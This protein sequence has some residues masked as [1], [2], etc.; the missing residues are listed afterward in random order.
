MPAVGEQS[1]QSS[2]RAMS[3]PMRQS[4]TSSTKIETNSSKYA[5]HE[6]ELGL[7]ALARASG[8]SRRAAQALSE[9]GSLNVAH[10]LLWDWSK[11]FSDLYER[12]CRETQPV[13]DRE[14]AQR[15][16]ATAR[17]LQEIGEQ[18]V[19]RIADDAEN[20]NAGQAANA[21]QKVSV[22]RGIAIDKL[23]L[24]RN[25]PTEIKSYSTKDT[26]NALGMLATK[27]G[28]LFP[29]QTREKFRMLAGP[30]FDAEAVEIPPEE[31]D[32]LAAS[33]DEDAER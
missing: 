3:K 31:S 4:A 16:E 22:S 24:Y 29:E 15:E 7:R 1:G 9:S 2:E 27:Y 32:E 19:D 17:R 28:H 18:L 5:A 21:L 12:I 6:I 14:I 25:Q 20:L 10:Q 30:E 23:R 33:G 13:I 26:A 8:N 11:R